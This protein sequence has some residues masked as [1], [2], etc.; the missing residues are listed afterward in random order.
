MPSYWSPPVQP[1]EDGEDRLVV[2]RRDADAVVA[3]EQRRRV[4]RQGADFDLRPRVFVELQPVG[5]I[6]RFPGDRRR[7][8]LARCVEAHTPAPTRHMPAAKMLSCV[9]ARC[10]GCGWCG[11]L[12]PT[13]P[14]VN[15]RSLD[16]AEAR[17]GSRSA[18][19]PSV[20]FEVAFGDSVQT[21][22]FDAFWRPRR[23]V[24]LAGRVRA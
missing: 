20:R 19:A 3:D 12:R 11:S 24:T 10:R 16:T 1:T 17:A 7:R 18:I 4:G 2:H 5:H 14:S 8:T 22:E 9:A 15:Y 13:P 6:A 21:T 23:R